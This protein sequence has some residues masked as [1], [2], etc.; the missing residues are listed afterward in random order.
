MHCSVSVLTACSPPRACDVE[1]AEPDR[2]EREIQRAETALWQRMPVDDAA[3][4]RAEEDA[5]VEPAESVSAAA[6]DQ[7]RSTP[8]QDIA[9]DD[10]D[11]DEDDAVLDATLD[12]VCDARGSVQHLHGLFQRSP[13]EMEQGEWEWQWRLF[14]ERRGTPVPSKMPV[15][16]GVS[17]DAYEMFQL[18]YRQGGLREVMRQTHQRSHP[19]ASA[20]TPG[21][22]S[23]AMHDFVKAAGHGNEMWNVCG[24]YFRTIVRRVKKSYLELLLPLEAALAVAAP[25]AASAVDGP[26]DAPPAQPQD[27]QRLER[28][29]GGDDERSGM[30]F[31]RVIVSGD[32]SAGGKE[33]GVGSADTQGR[34]HGGEKLSRDE[35]CEQW[36]E[37]RE[38]KGEDVTWP[39]I[40]GR[41]VDLYKLFQMVEEDGGVDEVSRKRRWREMARC[42]GF[43]P[44]ASGTVKH[45]Y[46][47]Q[48]LNFS[49]HL[50]GI[51]EDVMPGHMVVED[52]L[53]MP[54]NLLLQECKKMSDTLAAQGS[55]IEGSIKAASGFLQSLSLGNLNI[56]TSLAAAAAA[57]PPHGVHREDSAREG[58]GPAGEEGE[59]TGMDTMLQE[60][61][62][63]SIELDASIGS[64]ADRLKKV[65]HSPLKPPVP[66]GGTGGE[67]RGGRTRQMVPLYRQG[68]VLYCKGDCVTINSGDA[69]EAQPFL[70]QLLSFDRVRQQLEVR[71]LY[72]S[73]E[74]E[75]T[76]G[77][78]LQRYRRKHFPADDVSWKHSEW[79][80]EHEVFFSFHVDKGVHINSVLGLVT[81]FFLEGYPLDANVRMRR[82]EYYCR[83]VWDPME[84]LIYYF[85]ENDFKKDLR[86]TI[87]EEIQ[88]SPYPYPQ[89]PSIQ[90][91]VHA[92]NSTLTVGGLATADAS[93]LTGAA[94]KTA[95]P[96]AREPQHQNQ[97]Q[98]SPWQQQSPQRD[99]SAKAQGT[100]LSQLARG[101]PGGGASPRPIQRRCPF[102]KGNCFDAV[103]S[104]PHDC[105]ADS[106]SAA[107]AGRQWL[108]LIR[109]TEDNQGLAMDCNF[110]AWHAHM[111]RLWQQQAAVREQRRL[112]AQYTARQRQEIASREQ[113]ALKLEEAR[114]KRVSG[115]LR[116]L[117]SEAKGLSVIGVAGEEWRSAAAVVGQSL[118]GSLPRTWTVS[119]IRDDA[120]ASLRV[121]YRPPPRPPAEPTASNQSDS[122][123]PV[124]LEPISVTLDSITRVQQ[125]LNENVEINAKGSSR[126]SGRS[127]LSIEKMLHSEV[128]ARR[129]TDSKGGVRHRNSDGNKRITDGVGPGLTPDEGL[130]DE[131]KECLLMLNKRKAAFE[132]QLKEAEDWHAVLLERNALLKQ[133]TCCVKPTVFVIRANAG[134]ARSISHASQALVPPMSRTVVRQRSGRVVQEYA[135]D[136]SLLPPRAALASFRRAA[137]VLDRAH[138]HAHSGDARNQRWTRFKESRVLDPS[139]RLCD[140][141]LKAGSKLDGGRRWKPK[142]GRIWWE[143][144]LSDP[145]L[146][147]PT[148]GS[149][150]FYDFQ[151]AAVDT[152]SESE[153]ES[154]DARKAKRTQCLLSDQAAGLPK[155]ARDFV[156]RRVQRCSLDSNGRAVS[157][158][159]ATVV[160]YVPASVSGFVSAKTGRVAALWRLKFHDDVL[161]EEELE[162]DEL[163]DAYLAYRMVLSDKALQRDASAGSAWKASG[164]PF[165][166]RLVRRGVA[167]RHSTHA[168]PGGL[169]GFVDGTIRAWLPPESS[170]FFP[171]DSSAP[172][173]LF[174]VMY[175][176]KEIGVEDL[177][178]DQVHQAI[179]AYSHAHAQNVASMGDE[180]LTSG[181][182]Y[183]GKRIRRSVLDGVGRMKA[184]DGVVQGWLPAELSRF[185]SESSERPAALWRVVYDDALI[186]QEDLEDFEVEEAVQV[187]QLEVVR[188]TAASHSVQ[189]AEFQLG[190]VAQQDEWLTQGN[191][192]L[193]QRVRRSIVDHS[194]VSAVNVDG[195]I[196]GWL[197]AHMSNYFKDDDPSQPAALWRV[198]YDDASIGQE[199]LEYDEVVGAAASFQA[200]QLAL[201]SADDEWW[202]KGNE[203]L[204]RRVR[205]FILDENQKIVNTADAII[206]GWLPAHVSTFSNDKG[207]PA[208]LWRIRYDDDRIGE[209]DLEL[210]EVEEALELY[211]KSMQPAPMLA[212]AE[213]SAPYTCTV[214]E[215]DSTQKGAT[216]W[217]SMKMELAAS[218]HASAEKMG[219]PTSQSSKHVHVPQ[220]TAFVANM[221]AGAHVLPA[222]ALAVSSTSQLGGL[223]HPNTTQPMH[224]D[225]AQ[226]NPW[227]GDKAAVE[228]FVGAIAAPASANPSVIPADPLAGKQHWR[229]DGSDFIGQR[230]R[231][232]YFDSSNNNLRV[233]DGTVHSWV[234]AAD[235][236]YISEK[237]GL[238][239]PLWLVVY[240]DKAVG[241]E[242]LEASEVQDALAEYQAHNPDSQT[243]LTDAGG[244]NETDEWHTTGSEFLGKRVRR[245]VPTS[246]GEGDDRREEVV[247]LDASIKGWLPADVSDFYEDPDTKLKPAALWR[248]VYDDVRA[249]E[250]DLEEHEVLE[251]IAAF[252]KHQSQ[253]RNK[254]RSKSN[255]RRASHVKGGAGCVGGRDK[256]KA[257]MSDD[258]SGLHGNVS[259]E[260]WLVDGSKYLF[261]RVRYNS[262]DAHDGHFRWQHGRII[263]WQPSQRVAHSARKKPAALWRAVYVDRDGKEYEQALMEEE[264]ITGLQHYEDWKSEMHSKML[265]KDEWH[266]SGSDLLEQRLRKPVPSIDGDSVLLNATVLGWLPP[267][268]SNFF[269]NADSKEPAALYR[270]VFDDERVGFE[271]LEEEEVRAFMDAL[272]T[273]RESTG[274]SKK[275]G[276]ARSSASSSPSKRARKITPTSCGEDGNKKDVGIG[277]QDEREVEELLGKKLEAGKVLYLV[278]WK[279]CTQQ[280]DTWEEAAALGKD[281]WL[282]SEW[283]TE[284]GADKVATVQDEEVEN[285]H[286]DQWR[287]EGSEWIG[288]RVLASVPTDAGEVV[289]MLAKVIHDC[290]TLSFRPFYKL[291]FL[292]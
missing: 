152:E 102:K 109:T 266:T 275:R 49:Y 168:V 159:V 2:H 66:S 26:R 204:G 236:N 165:I 56:G 47:R 279:G 80:R 60:R 164:H 181:N 18:A 153:S 114:L 234:T 24:S 203:F 158:A 258:G 280:E 221:V 39:H 61:M 35:W 122:T 73:E 185:W 15:V 253:K 177:D 222:S 217:P 20:S 207:E 291:H 17:F 51:D 175:H 226:N 186:G 191:A 108:Q 173:P 83:S 182:S 154:E 131:A 246:N 48:L 269:P 145:V 262:D 277:A 30:P 249:G 31:R 180:W 237:T 259:P 281:E 260:E 29:E 97:H 104:L 43:L 106:I 137:R 161:G 270:I 82:G 240:D 263:G 212:S 50:N 288:E 9:G 254:S 40:A 196:V 119:M 36:R 120:T 44:G 127:F 98:H 89:L 229:T 206:R 81:V 92:A 223:P 128:A 209:E 202:T 219:L 140:R 172:Q 139:D 233:V 27:A 192:F 67:E 84:K 265:E 63:R 143:D 213:L 7:S 247:W 133:S 273:G 69:E 214:S 224:D 169:S 156:G 238:A 38:A 283:E 62:A 271:D 86:R 183:I 5:Q 179:A 255:S 148:Y 121:L 3:A 195:T 65:L 113:A 100:D 6:Q 142:F 157:A 252:K 155:K 76:A 197:P 55:E 70:A 210:A 176:K 201:Q 42:L 235:S 150:Q 189:A 37:F 77:P 64:F 151:S 124:A 274:Q 290:Q 284:H 146:R 12:S 289:Q 78:V 144:T 264:V 126:M 194:K 90:E 138:V 147:V 130:I 116:H 220:D 16:A 162:Y 19:I 242:E 72:R 227:S 135:M 211:N 125:H 105:S 45:H 285:V 230:V 268:Q 115:K 58:Q 248:C 10:G 118:A 41:Q 245:G 239:S 199:D 243:V 4:P 286:E 215:Q 99:R 171:S 110:E 244:R 112:A 11:S 149:A 193:G 32:S 14:M 282:V 251:G 75:N 91:Q 276:S 287:T 178:L 134:A 87:D 46:V 52:P 167:D 54:N 216:Q 257:T 85:G 74:V 250:E 218:A 132:K 1:L 174:R 278:H 166:G 187:Y 23:N 198:Q 107:E 95:L 71:W 231:R 28:D 13:L 188:A 232:T 160:D 53:D 136:K 208:P 123:A 241:E 117:V 129:K 200:A 59:A 22:A 33:T 272:E 57:N 267:E 25:V 103:P 292:F 184:V 34:I 79:N 21:S 94:P 228:P 163:V 88:F 93:S 141:V 205:R 256:A 190:A 8:G 225:V 261:K 96:S 68:S 111:R 170:N 101:T